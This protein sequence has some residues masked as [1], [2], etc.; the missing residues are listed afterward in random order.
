MWR[1]QSSCSRFLSRLCGGEQQVNWSRSIR[2]FLSRLCGGEQAGR[3]HKKI[4]V[5]LSR[6]CGGEL[7]QFSANLLYFQ[8][9]KER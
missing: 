9:V 3:L 4:H 7:K 1:A 2:A 5:F 6:L 8:S